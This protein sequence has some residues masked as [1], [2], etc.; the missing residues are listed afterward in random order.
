MMTNRPELPVPSTVGEMTESYG[1]RVEWAAWGD[2]TNQKISIHN[3]PKR[4]HHD[5]DCFTKAI[6]QSELE[7]TLRDGARWL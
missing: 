7:R 3:P 5:K 6:C 1:W 2:K 4:I